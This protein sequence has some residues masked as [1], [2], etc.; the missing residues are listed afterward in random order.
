M[1]KIF[2]LFALA[3][4]PSLPAQASYYDSF[5]FRPEGSCRDPRNLWFRQSGSWFRAELGRDAQGRRKVAD[6]TLQ[7][8][9]NHG[10]WLDYS[11]VVITRYLPHGGTE[12]IEV[13]RGRR[14]GTWALNGN[15]LVLPG[16]LVGTPARIADHGGTANGFAA[17]F[18]APIRD[19]RLKNARVIFGEMRTKV[20]PRGIT[21]R[22][23]CR[24]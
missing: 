19:P 17:S 13:F 3:L 4:L 24:P 14:A 7:L 8:F 6:I 15:R 16:L 10:Y 2:C 5:T 21:V 20:G 23:F 9:P 18:L 12:G 1:K 11:E 22:E